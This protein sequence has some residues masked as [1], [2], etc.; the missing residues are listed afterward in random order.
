MKKKNYL[1]GIIILCASL[2]MLSCKKEISPDGAIDGSAPSEQ[3]AL[4]ANS[5]DCKPT[6]FGVFVR[7]PDGVTKWQTLM[8]KWY[9]PNGKLAY[10]KAHY[11]WDDDD[12][13]AFFFSL[14]FGAVTYHGN[15]VV[16]TDVF[17][18]KMVFRA[19]LNTDG[20]PEATYFYSDPQ[21]GF[22]G[23]IDTT[24]YYYTGARLDSIFM[25]HRFGPSDTSPIN[26]I[27]RFTYD[28]HGN[29][30]RIS[31]GDTPGSFRQQFGYNYGQLVSGMLGNFQF[32]EPLKLLEY[33]DLLKIPVHHQLTD[34]VAGP[35][36]PGFSYPFDIYPIDRQQY[37]D[38]ILDAGGR[39]YSYIDRGASPWVNTL[40]TGWECAGAAPQ[41]ATSM[42]RM[43]FI[44]REDFQRKYPMPKK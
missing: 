34:V 29:L 4:Q 30:L 26:G 6:V 27:Y 23:V 1:H 7:R 2:L 28:M 16:V 18:N 37:T 5:N 36:T 35:Y 33:M 14:D 10:L 8:Q 22:P 41:A 32:S 42:E 40:Y 31:S 11:I 20:L 25:I 43:G 13:S 19:T 39:V 38:H 21:P 17:T 12:Y 24:Y 9:D 44:T 15:Q 3:A